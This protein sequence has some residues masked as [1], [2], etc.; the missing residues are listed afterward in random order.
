MRFEIAERLRPSRRASSSFESPRS[1]TSAAHARASSTGLR[2]SRATFSI[3]AVC[4]RSASA[5][6]RTIAG[7][8]CTPASRAARHRRS[9]AISS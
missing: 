3:S 8:V 4:S 1:S 6:S 5:S 7:T 2:S 9:P